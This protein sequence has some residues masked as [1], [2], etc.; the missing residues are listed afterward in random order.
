M[1]VNTAV[2]GMSD[3]IAALRQLTA[4]A[5]AAGTTFGA[6]ADA[7][8]DATFENIVWVTAITELDA[9]I[10]KGLPGSSFR[11]LIDLLTNYA[12][13]GIDLTGPN[14]LQSYLDS[15]KSGV[16]Y[17]AGEAIT[18][19][20]G[21]SR[22]LDPKWVFSKGTLVATAADQAAAGMHEFIE[23]QGEAAAST[24]VAHDGALDAKVFGAVMMAVSQ[25]A[26]CS[27][28]T[29]LVLR[30]TRND[31]TTVD[32]TTA[33]LSASSQW[34]KT[35]FG[36]QIVNAAGAAAGQKVIPIN[37]ITAPY[38][39]AEQVLIRQ[40]GDA[41][42]QEVGIVAS[43]VA[44]TSITLVENLVNTYAAADLVFPKYTNVAWVSGTMTQDKDVKIYAMP[45]RVIAK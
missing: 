5:T 11:T 44:N 13:N 33:A 23:I 18:E 29:D 16:P 2:L 17:E 34:A 20:F 38:K 12:H 32:L 26:T 40:A 43:I 21:A 42:V 37:G 41:T 22:T 4:A 27:I 36:M 3:R 15:I 9:E 25:N 45:D 35:Y 8:A 30:F 24:V 7:A 6:R 14:Y 31:A 28:A 1:A 39:A 19:A 10:A